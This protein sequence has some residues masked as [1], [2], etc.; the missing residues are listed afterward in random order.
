MSDAIMNIGEVA[1][2]SR[3]SADLAGEAPQALT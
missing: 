1:R 2:A 3:V